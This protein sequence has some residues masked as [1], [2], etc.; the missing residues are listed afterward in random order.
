MLIHNTLEKLRFMKLK[1]MAKALEDQMAMPDS[2]RLTF[3]ERFGLLVDHEEI[4]RKNLKM[5][6]RLKNAKLREAACIEDINFSE[7]RGLDKAMIL[8][9][10]SGEWIRQ[11][12]NIII[13]GPT[14]VGKTYLGCALLHSAC[15]EGFS[16]KYLR[17]P[18]LLDE[19]TI[20]RAN[21]TY[22]KLLAV[23]AKFDLLLLDDW[24]LSPLTGDESRNILE[25]IEDRY[26]LKSS[27]ITSQLPPEKWFE[28]MPDPTIADAILDRVIHRSHKIKM[29]GPSMRKI[30]ANAKGRK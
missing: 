2:Q 23:Y 14:G 22:T 12:Q 13:S 3:D 7:D 17:V 21:G 4:A 5:A 11:K 8:G 29:K 24:G 19:I 20:A 18:R 6:T 28:L 15:R 16:G 9:F 1:G 27:I 25:I 26:D 30:Q 10:S